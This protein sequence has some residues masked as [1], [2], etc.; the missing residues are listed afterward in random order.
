M[1]LPVQWNS[2]EMTSDGSLAHS[3]VGDGNVDDPC[4]SI[5]AQIILCLLLCCCH[6]SYQT[7]ENSCG[8]N[9]TPGTTNAV[10]A[11]IIPSLTEPCSSS[12]LSSSPSAQE[13]VWCLHESIKFGKRNSL[14]QESS[15]NPETAD[16]Y[17][18]A[19]VDLRGARHHFAAIFQVGHACPQGANG[20]T[21]SAHGAPW[22]CPSCSVQVPVS[23][24]KSLFFPACS[25]W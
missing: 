1:S 20:T 25:W 22:C 13:V 18:W 5:P 7:S 19:A 17:I 4:G 2:L 24:S 10:S 15:V 3:S 21:E 16:A 11:S 6:Y 9:G 14:S 8:P 23:F 12:G